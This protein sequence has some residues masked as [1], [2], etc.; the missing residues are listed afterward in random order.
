MAFVDDIREVC[1]S[2]IEE[3]LTRRE[4]GKDIFVVCLHCGADTQ[5]FTEDPWK[6]DRKNIRHKDGCPVAAAHRVLES[7]EYDEL[8][9]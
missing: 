7:K 6:Y 2:V 1:N 3:G 4:R 9:D 5:Y 8:P